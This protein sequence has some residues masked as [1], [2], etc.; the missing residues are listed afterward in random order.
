MPPACHTPPPLYETVEVIISAAR[1]MDLY[2]AVTTVLAEAEGEDLVGKV[3]V[4]EVIRNRMKLSGH[5]AARVVRDPGQFA[6]L[7]DERVE[8]LSGLGDADPGRHLLLRTLLLDCE[9]AVQRAFRIPTN[10]TKG[11]IF[12]A[13]REKVMT[14]PPSH[15]RRELET[16]R[17]GNHVFWGKEPRE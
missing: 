9:A 1:A 6:Q 14:D 3:A 15:Y 17:H 10:H 12:F 13:T 11:A 8:A 5:R 2:F 7:S 16:F 4:A